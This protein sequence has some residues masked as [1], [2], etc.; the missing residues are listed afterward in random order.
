M[1]TDLTEEIIVSEIV[2]FPIKTSMFCKVQSLKTVEV[3]SC[4]ASNKAVLTAV[5]PMSIISFNECKFLSKI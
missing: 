1:S 2:C 3:I 5:F 4:L